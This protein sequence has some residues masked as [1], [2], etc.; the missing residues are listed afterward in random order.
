MCA[1]RDGWDESAR[2]KAIHVYQ[3]LSDGRLGELDYLRR[4]NCARYELCEIPSNS[5][6]SS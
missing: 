1:T 3:H 2:R 4:E 5:L 6:I